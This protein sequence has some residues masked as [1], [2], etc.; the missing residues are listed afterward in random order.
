MHKT[1]AWLWIARW[2]SLALALLHLAGALPKWILVS[3]VAILV[4]RL[5]IPLLLMMLF[6]PALIIGVTKILFAFSLMP[7]YAVAIEMLSAYSQQS[8]IIA[9]VL[10]ALFWK[11]PPDVDV[12]KLPSDFNPKLLFGPYNPAT[13]GFACSGL[14]SL[15][16]IERQLPSYS[17][18]DFAGN[19][20]DTLCIIWLLG[21]LILSPWS[22][23]HL[24][25]AVFSKQLYISAV[26]THYNLDAK[27]GWLGALLALIV[28]HEPWHDRYYQITLRRAIFFN[29]FTFWLLHAVF[30]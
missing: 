13:I 21:C 23:M 22:F 24:C 8:A 17:Y 15:Y 16:L 9:F 3:A 27:G 26:E 10:Y 11:H 29:Q 14:I 19:H 2:F 18:W 1:E 28:L 12:Y 4:P 7:I 25:R 20:H 5:G 6:I 30:S